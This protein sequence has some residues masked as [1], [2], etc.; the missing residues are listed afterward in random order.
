MNASDIEKCLSTLGEMLSRRGQV[1]EIVVLGGASLAVRELTARAT[2]DVDVLGIR[3]PDGSVKS[4]H[5]LPS[6][7]REAA[8]DV[9]A[10][11]GLES[12]WLDDRPGSH[13]ASAAPDGF[14]DRLERRE[15][16]PLSVWHLAE[17]DILTIKLIVSADLWGE[18]PNKHWDD[19][20]ALKPD[21]AAFDRA[22]AFAQKVWTDD[23]PAWK[24]LAEME[25]MLHA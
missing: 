5:P 25:A 3:L 14:E 22:R 18:R 13:F 8:A 6:Y 1:A 15:Y 24:F 2:R 16:G 7:L 19:V 11:L 12:D 23:N 4:A 9:A 21:S 10:V 17:S 20:L